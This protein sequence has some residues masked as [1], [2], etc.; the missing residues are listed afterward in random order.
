MKKISLFTVLM[1]FM[2]AAFAQKTINGKIT[3][4]TSG[5]PLA[6]ATI[7]YGNKKGTTTDKNGGFSLECGKTNKITISFVGYEPQTINIKNC[8]EEVN[9]GLTA[10]GQNLE[11]VE[12]S[13]TSAQNKSLLSQPVSITKLG[14]PDLKRGQGVFFDDIIQTSVPGVQMN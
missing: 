8:D 10:L 4:K 13:A 5:A 7:S 9:I 1:L 12:I 6:G 14:I 2:I 3:D 11:N